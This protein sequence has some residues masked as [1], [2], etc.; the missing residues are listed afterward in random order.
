MERTALKNGH[1]QNIIGARS[2]ETMVSKSGLEMSSK[3]GI[4]NCVSPKKNGCFTIAIEGNIGSGKSTMINYFK[5]FEEVQ[6]HA[7]P[8]SKWTDVSGENLLAKLYEDPKRWSF[9]FQSYVQLTRL[10][11]VTKPLGPGKKTKVIERS[12]QNNR[13][14]FLELNKRKGQLTNPEFSVLDSWWQW[15]DTHMGLD[16]DLIVYLRTTPD[17]AFDRMRS[18]GRKEESGAPLDYIK[19]LHKSYEDWLVER[20]FGDDLPPVL[21]L[22]ANQGI[23]EMK[24]LYTKHEKVI[25][26][27]EPFKEE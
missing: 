10:Q 13:F 9:Q 19:A 20:K 17:V 16:L 4:V 24:K 18:R 15:L 22:D 12:V 14:C 7:E 1:S 11:I 8:L 27:I 5:Q 23:E 25:R 3:D 2:Q 26:G 21:I 6:V